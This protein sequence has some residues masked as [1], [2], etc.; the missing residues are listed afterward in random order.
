MRTIIVLTLASA[1]ASTPAHAEWL[2]VLPGAT[3]HVV[4]TG[5]HAAIVRDQEVLVLD[6][7]GRVTSRLG[8]AEVAGK[9]NQGPSLKHAAEQT[10]DRL[11]VPEIDRGTDYTDDLVEDESRVGERRFWRA[12]RRTKAEAV[13]HGRLA[14]SAS[15]DEIWIANSRG[16]F[17]VGAAGAIVPAFG[18]EWT[19]PRIAAASGRVVVDKGTSLVLLSTGGA[20]PELVNLASPPDHL[21]VSASA[22]R[23]AWTSSTTLHVASADGVAKMDGPGDIVHLTFCG[24]TLIALLASSA[25]LGIPPRGRAELRSAPPH[26]RKLVC[27]ST[28]DA[29]WVAL[30]D[31]LWLSS[32]QGQQWTPVPS[33]AGTR[34]VDVAISDSHFWLATTTGLFVSVDGRSAESASGKTGRLRRADRPSHA[35]W[36]SWL[37]PNVSVRAAATFAPTGR[38][39]EGFA[40]A[41][42]PLGS[43]THP[44]TAVSTPESPAVSEPA[45]AIEFRD[46]DASCLTVARRKAVALAMTE[47]ERARSYVTRAGHTAWLPELRVLV[48]RRYGRSESLDVSSS[49]TS[50]SSPLGI[51]TVNDL[52]YE[53][54]A[55]WDLGRLIFS[56]EELAAQAQALHMAELRR[57]IETTINRLY[58]ERRRL[59]VGIT[60]ESSIRIREVE[61]ELDAMSADAFGACMAD[62][63]AG[64]Q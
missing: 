40:F 42:F 15:T 16:I 64:A 3:S 41:A 60:R 18:R 48:S 5:R 21:A 39:L 29:P 63:A 34:L 1:F 47:P 55:T 35:S 51:D 14:I 54:R 61:A 26:A 57:D 32:D 19:G 30:G 58:F 11:E 53:A 45:A 49:S 44:V 2:A 24:E 62:G 59:L 12:S 31:G 20:E 38:R 17:R 10:L 22:Q 56:P 25:V 7:D 33:P 9:I 46:A 6:E 4:A 36:L 13:Q 8:N 50:L 27:A 52:R 23:M 37:L 43:Q 28:A